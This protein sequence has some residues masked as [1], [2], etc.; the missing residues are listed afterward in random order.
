[1]RSLILYIASLMSLAVQATQYD[2]FDNIRLP[3]DANEIN[4]VFQDSYGMVWLGTKRGLLNYNGYDTH[5]LAT[6]SVQTIIQYNSF[7][8]IGTDDGI[9]WL[10]L[11]NGGID[12]KYEALNRIHAVRSLLVSKNKLWIGTRDDGLFI[13]DLDSGRLS[14]SEIH[15]FNETMIFS[16]IEGNH[17]VYVG[18]HEGFSCYDYRSTIRRKVFSCENVYSLYRQTN[19]IWIGAE[20]ILY[21]YDMESCKVVWKLDMEGNAVKTIATDRNNNLLLGTNEGFYILDKDKKILERIVHNTRDPLSLGNN[22]INSIICDKNNNIWL[23]TNRGV[24]VT[25][26]LP[27]YKIAHLSGYNSQSVGNV[28]ECSLVD[29]HQNYWLGGENGLLQISG[30]EIIKC[31]NVE[32][33]LRHNHIRSIYEDRDSTL[34]ITSDGS[35]ARYNRKTDTFIY[36]IIQDTKGHNANWAY[37]MYEDESHRL[38]IGTYMGGL[39][40]IDKDKLI[41]S[42]GKYTQT[43]DYFGSYSD[44]VNTVYQICPDGTGK[45]WLNTGKGLVLIDEKSFKTEVKD[46]YLDNMIYDRGTIYFSS[47]GQLYKYDARLFQSTGPLLV[48]NQG[49]IYSFVKEN[50]HIWFSCT[51]GIYCLNTTNG[52]IRTVHVPYNSYFSGT[53][54]SNTDEMIWGGEDCMSRFYLNR[55]SSEVALDSVYI[56]GIVSNGKYHN[57]N[58]IITREIKLA[59]GKDLIIELSPLSFNPHSNGVYYYKIGERDTWHSLGKGINHLTFAD[60]P[61]GYH[62]LLLSSEN[63]DLNELAPISI[64]QIY[65]PYPWYA[66]WWAILGYTILGIF[67]IYIIIRYLQK[68][69]QRIFE[70]REQEKSL[71]LSRQKMD[72]FVNVSHELKTPLSLIIAPLS[73][74][75]SETTNAKQRENLKAIHRNSLRLNDLIYK[76]LDF[77]RIE[78][79]SEDTLIRSHVELCQLLKNCIQTFSLET[80]KRNISINFHSN[81]KT[82]WINADMLKLESVFINL[83]SNALKYVPDNTGKVDVTIESESGNATILIADNGKGMPEKEIPMMFIRYFQGKNAHRGGTGIGLYLVRKFIELHSGNVEVYNSNG[84]SVKITLPIHGGNIIN[85]TLDFIE[86]SPEDTKEATLLIV[87]DNTEIVDF[88]AESLSKMYTCL[89]AYNGMEGQKVICKHTID[90]VIVDQMMPEMDGFDFCKWLR[91]QHQTANIPIIMLTAKDDTETELQ[92]IKVGV[93]VFISKPFDIKKVMLHI[94]QLLQR[95]KSIERAA[96]IEQIINPEFKPTDTRTN[97][98]ILMEKIT[99][100][101][102]E[103]MEDVEFNVTRLSQLLNIDQKQLYRKI[104][105]LTGITPIAYLKKLRMKKAAVLLRE[106]RFTISEVMYLVGYT[107]AS[108][109]TKCFTEEFGMSPKQFAIDHFEKK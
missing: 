102:E 22:V 10:D 68:R 79:E 77:K 52:S 55:L 21:Q 107:N 16:L 76:I 71:E 95:R 13:L 26:G 98:E 15:N 7:L 31:W 5:I 35:I 12:K 24:S 82:L 66:S 42:K 19:D 46:V 70:Q 39:Y 25:Q 93:D 63:P 28:F 3:Y 36:Y 23:G 100:A 4:C 54:N 104:K 34:W 85:S 29:S 86:T 106:D 78:Y 17:S 99:K 81:L 57:I 61:S 92:S 51:D 91:H 38:W 47:A 48:V 59:E 105:T 6:G 53:Y 96:N 8:C 101:I 65:V 74:M 1:M 83:L 45:L 14:H 80:N 58:P 32:N 37:C 18:S 75:I 97:D 30:D 87:D 103:N 88:L 89:K 44:I 43:E 69:N 27:W 62:K 33:G 84:L 73:Q 41:H 56:T 20:G 72:F 9:L 94:V 50:E 108:Y 11:K 90:L 64:Y 67:V 40:I 2:T 109:F 49:L 60:F